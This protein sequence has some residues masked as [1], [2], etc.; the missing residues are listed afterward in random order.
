MRV[1]LDEKRHGHPRPIDAPVVREGREG[2]GLLGLSLAGSVTGIQLPGG[3]TG[4]LA[5]NLTVNI[6]LS[7]KG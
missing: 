2:V 5:A 3:S 1:A 4:G 6:D 7:G